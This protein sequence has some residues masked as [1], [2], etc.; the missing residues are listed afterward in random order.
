[1]K[2]FT[3]LIQN[4]SCNENHTK[5]DD[6]KE[7]NDL[8]LNLEVIAND[9]LLKASPWRCYSI[10]KAFEIAQDILFYRIRSET[11]TVS[12]YENETR[13]KID[14]EDDDDDH[15]PNDENSFYR[16]I[17]LKFRSNERSFALSSDQYQNREVNL[18]C[19]IIA[20]KFHLSLIDLIGR[21][22]NEKF[23]PL[24]NETY[25][26]SLKMDTFLSFKILL[27]KLFF[28]NHESNQLANFVH[29]TRATYASMNPLIQINEMK[30]TPFLIDNLELKMKESANEA[31]NYFAYFIRHLANN[32]YDLNEKSHLF[33][34][35]KSYLKNLKNSSSDDSDEQKAD[36]LFKMH[37]EHNKAVMLSFTG[38]NSTDETQLSSSSLG[39]Q[40][41]QLL[42]DNKNRYQVWSQQIIAPFL[43]NLNEKISLNKTSPALLD[44][45]TCICQLFNSC[46]P[47]CQCLAFG[48]NELIE[49]AKCSSLHLMTEFF[50][51]ANSNVE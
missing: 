5:T 38:E 47:Y 25:L 23:L 12:N 17:S 36:K 11:E 39:G 50:R 16:D 40:R 26:I 37:Q 35:E 31:H 46:S 45:I 44:A 21:M 7:E 27:S 32:Y 18:T 30:E 48:Q 4:Y 1:M 28:S 41:S 15:L 49:R 2:Q 19:F 22:E 10:K 42:L 29:L 51:L 8:F 24:L 34:M 3:N 13:S 6:N 9:H 20:Y 43:V 33:K 14:Q